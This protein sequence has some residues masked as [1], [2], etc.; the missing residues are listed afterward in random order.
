MARRLKEYRARNTDD[1]NMKEFFTEAI[2]YQNVLL[3]DSAQPGPEQLVKMREIIEQKG[4]PCCIN[5]IT[6]E[7]KKFLL[8]LKKAAEKE[9]RA[10]AR[11][12]AAALAAEQEVPEPAE[13]EEEVKAPVDLESEEEVD[14]LTVLI[15]NEERETAERLAA[16][17]IR[18][19][20]DASELEI[21]KTKD[22]KEAIKLEKLRDQ[23]RDLL[24]QRSQPIRQYLMDNVVPHLTE[25]LIDLCKT[26]PD[27]P[28]DYLANFLLAKADEIDEKIIK[29]REEAAAA[30]LEAKKLKF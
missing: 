22:A 9:A 3:I 23:E 11:A 27:D 14:E 4:K 20:Q 19:K 6:E 18:K 5:M 10:K 17:E 13:G 24:D 7:D 21:R 12:E 25:G 1:S 15:L 8:G 29:E 30:K 28:T 26:I 16:E 2:G